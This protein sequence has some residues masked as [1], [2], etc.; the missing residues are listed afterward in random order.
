MHWLHRLLLV[1]GLLV[2]A[3][4][5]AA[6]ARAD[7]R[8]EAAEHF[9]RG[10]DLY[11]EGDFRAAL[12]EFRR[13]YALAPN[14]KVLFNIGNVQ[15]QLGDYAG[16]KKTLEQYLEEGGAR[17]EGDRRAAVENDIRRLE[18]RVA[19]VTITIDVDEATVTIDDVEVGTSPLREPVAV[20]AGRRRISVRKSGYREE[21]KQLDLAGGDRQSLSIDLEPLTGQPLPPPPP[22]SGGEKSAGSGDVPWGAW[23]T[24]AGFGAG[25]LVFGLL[26]LNAK[27]NLDEA[28]GLPTTA[29]AL[30]DKR[31][32]MLAFG[33][34]T[35]ILAAGTIIT[36]SVAIYLTVTAGDDAPS[37][38]GGTSEPAPEVAL[39]IGPAGLGLVGTF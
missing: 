4:A 37:S 26:A 20:S 1:L 19:Y 15:Y 5:P 30:T 7:A 35:D 13:A 21:T 18:Q 24:A 16:A 6:T 29:E 17:I 31:D 39:R 34:V 33:I 32:Q 8:D 14:F 9:K 22:P 3:V 28:K 2:A 12:I 23:A 38:S 10:T 25:T 27:A 11:D 36:G